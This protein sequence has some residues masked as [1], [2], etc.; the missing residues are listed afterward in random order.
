MAETRAELRAHEIF[1]TLEYGPVPESYACATV[2][3]YGRH[4]P[5][6]SPDLAAASSAQTPV[7]HRG[8]NAA[9]PLSAP[10]IPAT[11]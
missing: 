4:C 10:G 9:P 5:L 1:T 6:P 3:T 11:A 2:R 8:R 7:I